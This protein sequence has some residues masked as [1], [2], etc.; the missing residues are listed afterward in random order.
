NVGGWRM[1]GLLG[2]D[3]LQ[4]AAGE[5]GIDLSLQANRPP[6]LHEGGL[7]TFG[8]AGDSY[9][10]SRTRMEIYGSLL[11]KREQ[12]PV[13][14]LAWFD[15]QWGNFLVVG[16]GWDWFSLQLEDGTDLMLNV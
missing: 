12:I 1:N 9:Y 2:S 7:V 11:Y 3:R 14:D 15:K 13:T 4:A 6:V 8:P 10:Y 16:G 5:Y